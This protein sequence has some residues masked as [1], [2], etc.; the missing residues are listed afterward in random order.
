[1]NLPI[2]A[3]PILRNIS[4]AK[5]SQIKGIETSFRN[6]GLQC[7]LCCGNGGGMACTLAIPGCDCS[8]VS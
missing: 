8:N 3:L 6:A 1:M 4:T 2:Q 7:D 5:L